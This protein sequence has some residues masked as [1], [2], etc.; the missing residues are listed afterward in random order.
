MPDRRLGETVQAVV[1]AADPDHPP[2]AAD[3]REHVRRQLA[4]FKT[5]EAFSF[6]PELPRNQQGKVLRRV[7]AEQCTEGERR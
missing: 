2:A 7:L 3:L 4:G 5:P 6:V 1:V